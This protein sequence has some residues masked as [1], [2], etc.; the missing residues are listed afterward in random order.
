MAAHG[1]GGDRAYGPLARALHWTMAGLVLLQATFG[2]IMV[3]EGPEPNLWATLANALA[4]YDVHKL[5]GVVLLALVLVRLANRIL[6]GAPP[7]EPSL[8]PWQRESSALVHAWIYLL[9]VLVPVLGWIGVSL[10]P[11]LTLFGVLPLPALTAPDRPSSGPVLLAH[12]I[13]AFALLALIAAHAGA[14]LHHHF[15]RRDGVLRRMLP[16]LKA[17]E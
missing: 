12:A 6:R 9:L 17:R 15:I 3:Y 13:A 2:V 8:A 11:A 16:G 10:Y 7:E 4:L 1:N 14:A 5:L